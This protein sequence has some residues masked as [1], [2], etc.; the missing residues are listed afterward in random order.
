MLHSGFMFL[1]LVTEISKRNVKF[2][3]QYK[4]NF[5]LYHSLTFRINV[6]ALCEPILTYARD[7]NF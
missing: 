5:L 1:L 4:A 6:D 3:C 2:R 7:F